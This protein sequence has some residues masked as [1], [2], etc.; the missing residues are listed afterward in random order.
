M[1][2]EDDTEQPDLKKLYF[3]NTHQGKLG[4]IG[5]QTFYTIRYEA[6]KPLTLPFK[7]RP[8][9]AL[10]NIVSKISVEHIE[11]LAQELLN[12]GMACVIC[13]GEQAEETSDIIDDTIN[14]FGATDDHY[15]PYSSPCEESFSEALQYFA[16]PT[17]LTNTSIIITIGN[18]SDYGSTIESINNLNNAGAEYRLT[19][20]VDTAE[21]GA[22]CQE[23]DI[24]EL[25]YRE[26]LVDEAKYHRQHAFCNDCLN[27]YTF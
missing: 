18:T 12:Q 6:G 1:D 23:I 14:T 10:L 5:D 19:A 26:C 27:S 9:S 8:F 25:Y 11:L 4:K 2:F 7:K 24:R 22:D 15:T 16:L 20:A 13:N 3:S 17:G 21:S